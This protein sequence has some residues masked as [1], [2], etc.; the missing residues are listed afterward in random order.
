MASNESRSPAH[1]DPPRQRLT[2]PW[3][4]LGVAVVVGVTLVLIFPGRG[5]LTQSSRQKPDEV[6][7]T[8]LSNLAREQPGTGGARSLSLTI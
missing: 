6:S 3:T 8:Y 1:P 7:L 5:L 4:L 2:S